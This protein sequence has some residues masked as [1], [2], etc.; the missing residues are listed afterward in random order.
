MVESVIERETWSTPALEVAPIEADAEPNRVAVAIAGGPPV[1]EC[2]GQDTGSLVPNVLHF[3]LFLLAGVTLGLAFN[4]VVGGRLEHR[5]AQTDAFNRFRDELALGT[6]PKGPRDSFHGLISLGT[7]I[8]LL[9]I[10][11]IGVKEVVG[12]GTTSA[13]LMAGPGHLRS[14]PFPGGAGTSVIFGRAAAYGGPFAR[15]AQLHHGARITVTTQV[16]TSTFRVADLRRAGDVIPPLPAS[17]ARLTLVTAT[18]PAFLP[19]GVLWVDANLVQSLSNLGRTNGP[20]AAQRPA[21]RRVSPSELPLG[22]DVGALWM[23]GLWTILL[24]LVLAGAVLTWRR[25]EHARAWIIF[26]APV[27]LISYFVAGQIAL[28]LPNLM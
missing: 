20:L 27:A 2:P 5:V 14:T 21:V 24:M 28:L 16:G 8:A 17:G 12:E 25:G 13:V 22:I 4:L 7:P 6:A 19:S 1:H 3:G 15:L 10:P 9:E 23:A 11:S 26:S 18:G